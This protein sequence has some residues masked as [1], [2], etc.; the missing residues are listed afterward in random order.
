MKKIK[1]IE[2]FERLLKIQKSK[3]PPHANIYNSWKV[4]IRNAQYEKNYNNLESLWNLPNELIKEKPIYNKI[5][6][7]HDEF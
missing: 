5:L 1:S 2:D 4:D 6:N 7:I 3:I